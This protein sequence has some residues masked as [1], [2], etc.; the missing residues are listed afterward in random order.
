[1][2]WH[3]HGQERK[4][5]D[6]L[7]VINGF[8]GIQVEK[9]LVSGLASASLVAKE[10]EKTNGVLVLDIGAGT[11]DYAVYYDNNVVTS[12]VLAVGGDHLTNDLSLGLRIN[13]QQAE[14][15]KCK[16]GKAIVD[17]KDADEKIWLFGDQRIGDR[18]IARKSIYQILQVRVEELFSIIK[19][20]MAT[21]LP[22]I[23]LAGGVVLTGGT[24]H[25]P[26]IGDEA[27][28]IF[29]T[30]ARVAQV[31]STL[32]KGLNQPEYSTVLGLIYYG[33]REQQTKYET[34]DKTSLLSRMAK[35]F[36][37]R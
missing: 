11:T 17:S 25:L 13:T 23:T 8:G 12:G 18:Q 37:W 34:P 9:V 32:K 2:Y 6:S 29:N 16:W 5:R 19:K 30:R 27:A 22:E 33:M 14:E 28:R 15:I 20:E 24:A 1:M 21:S 26:H 36:S 10:E 7:H 3:I 4:V 35:A 31:D